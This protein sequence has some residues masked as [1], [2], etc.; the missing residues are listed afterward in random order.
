MRTKSKIA[1]AVVGT[2]LVAGLVIASGG[3]AT[4]AAFITGKDIKDQSIQSVDIAAAGVGSSEIRDGSVAPFDLSA[5][6]KSFIESKAG[7]PGATG[8]TGATGAKGDTG[9]TGAKGDA[10]AKGAQ[11]APGA[12]GPQG[13]PGAVGPQGL[14]GLGLQDGY[15]AV[16]KY[17]AGNTNQGAVATVACS[18][19]ADTAVS[20]G[21]QVLDFSKN[22][23]VSS[24]FPGRMDWST[25]TPK[26]GRLDGWIVQFGGTVGNSPEKV[27]IW[28]FCVPG[29]NTQVKTTY[30]QVEG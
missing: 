25:N 16:A 30:V 12:V 15:Y 17:N 1:S 3:A 28:A 14:T 20:G 8:A 10:G 19:P 13:A 7:K 29:L 4:A 27:N 2:G 11:G 18:D 9:A 23:P 5:S 6:T 22:T 21:V 24:S 26:E